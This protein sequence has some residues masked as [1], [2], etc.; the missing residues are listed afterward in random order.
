MM[1][2]SSYAIAVF[3]IAAATVPATFGQIDSSKL[4]ITGYQLLS[5]Q[6]LTRTQSYFTYRADVINTGPA[7]PAITATV[8]PISSSGIQVVS[9]KGN[10]HFTNVATNAQVTSDN[11]FTILVD[12]TLPFSFNSLQWSFNSPVANAGP[13]QTAS[14]GATVTLDA[15]RSSNPSA[16][17][18]LSYSWALTAVP[19]GSQA[20][21]RNPTGVTT[22]FV[23]DIAGNYVATVTVSNGAGSDY[24][25]V[26]ISTNGNT[27]PVANAGPDQSVKAGSTVFLDGSKSSDVDG[28]P[29]TYS[30]SF[31]QIPPGSQA[32]LNGATTVSPTFVADIAG[33][34]IAQLVVNDGQVNSAPDMVTIAV[35]PG[36]TAPTA[37]AGPSQTA[38]VGATVQLDG[39]RSTDV[40]GD[41]LTYKWSLITVPQGSQAAL[42]SSS[43]VN[44]VFTADIAGV[45]IAQLIV[46]DGKIDSQPATVT[47]T[48][49]S[50]GILA[51]TANAGLA[52]TVQYGATVTLSGSGTDPQSRPLT[53]KWS[54]VTLP[55]GS[56]A[57]LT[58]PTSANPTF[59]ADEPGTF[60][61]QLIVNNGALD[62]A[63]ATVTITSNVLQPVANPGQPQ[64][65]AIGTTVNLDGSG[66]SD[67]NNLPLTYKWSLTSAPAGSAAAILSASTAKTSFVADVAGM[68][69]VQLIVNNGFKDS[70]PQTITI[71]ASAGND[72][73]LSPNPL[74][75]VN[76]PGTLTISTGN[77]AG[78][79]GQVITLTVTD[80]TVVT[81]PGSVTIPQNQ[82]SVTASIAPAAPGTTQILA[83]A[84]G[85][86][87]AIV[88][89]NVNP[90]S[91]VLSLSANSVGV[92]K[93]VTGTVNLSAPAPAQG[94]TI[95]LSA[96]NAGIVS[97]PGSINIA[98]GQ[99]TGTFTITGSSQGQV[100]ITA[101]A[102][103]YGTNSQN[104]VVSTLGAIQL[105]SG[106]TVGTGQ[107]I[108]FGITLATP[109]PAGGVTI[110]L[111]S[112]DTTK[113]TVTPTV[114]IREGATLPDTPAQVTGAGV[115]SVLVTASAPGFTGDSKT[116]Q[117]ASA[118]TFTPPVV[119]LSTNST[120]N[121]S[122]ALSGT[123][124]QGGLVINL[125]SD[126]TSVASIPNTVT[127]AQNTSS[128]TVPVGGVFAG[129]ANITA[130]SAA[131]GILGATLKVNVVSGVA[132]TS[133]SLPAGVAGAAY[134]ASIAAS[135]GTRPYTFS[136]IGLPN[137]LSISAGGQ[138]SGTPQAA[139]TSQ[140]VI[141]ASD[142]TSPTK[143]TATA[144]FSLT[145]NAT[146]SITTTSLPAV[147]VNAAY[148]FSVMAN[149]GTPP[150]TFSATGLPAGLSMSAA[151]QITGS[152]QSLGTSSVAITATDSTSPTK[153]T[154]T[155]TLS[156]S[157][158]GPLSMTTT[159]LPGGTVNSAYNASVTASGG[160][161]PY[162]FSATGLPAGL[163]MNAAGQ[164]SGTPQ[165]GGTGSVVITVTD[166]AS[167]TKATATATLSLAVIQS[168]SITTSSLPA[169]ALNSP[170]TASVAASGGTQPYTFSAM[171]LPAGLSMNGA[172]QI[173]GM[174][175]AAGT[176]TVTVTV[177]DSTSPTKL[178]ATAQLSL[179]VSAPALTITTIQLPAGTTGNAYLASLQAKGG[180]AP[181]QWV[182]TSGTLP[183]GVNFDPSGSLSGTPTLVG[184]YPLSFR[185]SDSG[186]PA[187]SA[188][189]STSITISQGGVPGGPTLSISG[190]TVGNGLE[191]P[192][193]I[194][195][196][197]APSSGVNVTISSSNPA[198]VAVAELAAGVGTGSIVLPV[199][200][201]TA[202][203]LVYVQGL[204]SSGSATIMVSAPGYN[205]GSAQVNLARS[206]FVL[207]GPNAIGGSFVTNQSQDTALTVSAAELDSNGNV[208]QIQRVS[209]AS[210]VTVPLTVANSSLGSVSPSSIPFQ[211]GN[212][213]LIATFTAANTAGSTTIS[214]T[215]PAG[216]LTPAGAG[217][218]LAVT[219][220]PTL[221][222]ASNAT[223]G[224]GLETTAQVTL[225]GAT[226]SDLPVTISSN[227]PGKLLLS[228]D[229][230]AAGQGSLTI[231]IRAGFSRAQF[232]VYGLGNSGSV[233]YSATASGYGSS[234]GTVTLAKAGF[235]LIGP[236]GQGQDFPTTAQSQPS[237]LDVQTAM[238]NATGNPVASQALAGGSPVQVNVTSQ[239][240]SVGT[241]TTSPVNIAPG[242]FD[243]L[244]NFQPL[245]NGST[246]ISAVGPAP[247]AAPAQ[248][249]LTATVGTPKILISS[250]YT[251]GK[252][253]EQQASIIL[254]AAPP[255]DLTVTLTVTGGP[256]LLS[257]TG[258][259][260][261]SASVNVV[262]PANT[263]SGTFF[264]YGLDSTGAAT[265]TVSAPGYQSATAIEN[266]VPSGVVIGGSF[267][268]GSNVMAAAGNT[269]PVSIQTVQLD[270]SGNVVGT[271]PLAG[272]LTLTA[273]L[274]SSN[275]GV[276]TIPATASIAGG[277]DT[278]TVQFTAKAAGTTTLSV[279]QP[280]GYTAPTQYTSIQGQVQ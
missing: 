122:L 218:T 48:A 128:V 108:A 256:M 183:P 145:I 74:N 113:L 49:G 276:G 258:S 238:L 92:T 107:S 171:G 20:S 193:V 115:G 42:S 2:K 51:P 192:V 5:E 217:N 129:T 198:A 232:Y 195:F 161:Q 143:L 80:T 95:N 93:T 178:T 124:P 266:L 166:S 19:A 55:T 3:A 34:Y 222:V 163:S 57:V 170:Y 190:V 79:G 98:S 32:V 65:V 4:T 75:L 6:R 260:G 215:E 121:V 39:S 134:S 116:V 196:S 70:A 111:T 220:Q 214:L 59:V 153:L 56:Q 84:P 24:A 91:L 10:L 35:T 230:T 12:R 26:T 105:Q 185:V 69:V 162:S 253:L 81:A 132:I 44:P 61:A 88:T 278:G 189:L 240:T 269:Q 239:N 264:M 31:V 64:T 186:N 200:A 263:N 99:Q 135:G 280:S 201:G 231:T 76:S 179:T 182:I 151:G 273:N 243:A 97:L 102:M 101:T 204:A 58:N 250:G 174:P 112:A 118:L 29:L 22:S 37:N 104:L 149:G 87:P 47:I 53:Y 142:S 11:A 72:I 28:N 133:T 146:L 271:Q 18:T 184:S 169:G 127:I 106:L 23:P 100:T 255:S 234:N 235:V 54:L 261:G 120:Q 257:A 270:A 241:I 244:T 78:P 8:T 96:N 251:V 187:Q 136:A 272:G 73:T 156:L 168:L 245:S 83:S 277:S 147:A 43:I 191:V 197:P 228:T 140:V 114:F 85:F 227:D 152:A 254:A 77:P 82:T 27:A 66:S 159:S 209:G 221:I 40:D 50:G 199:D 157:V 90:G 265:I 173:T 175:Q 119:T 21:L 225:Q 229:P 188:T 36:N 141:T 249:S 236:F 262:I 41:P 194:T 60:V 212:D 94:V 211:G 158:I 137:G 30:W 203:F 123:A 117:I 274:S 110:T 268:Y 33:T 109:A 206:G 15:S 275:S 216:F 125:S 131:A 25:S 202:S 223:V 68:Y 224:Q 89:V 160:T 126:N 148:N 210:P 237:G 181:Y 62:S 226:P 63:P 38:T 207:S 252:N 138:I 180:A 130:S 52:Q 167:P 144:T 45:Y 13:D 259:D 67:P 103:G 139:G 267:G 248:G 154:A 165:S 7:L 86:H 177:T 279:S 176:S 14:V 213:S 172:G 16:I 150:Y 46:N 9:G 155:A 205:S 233:T 247:F 71:T 164:I 242:T 17:G 1:R 219:V 246:L 208:V